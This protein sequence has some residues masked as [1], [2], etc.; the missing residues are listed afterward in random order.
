[1]QSESELKELALKAIKYLKD[2][3]KEKEVQSILELSYSNMPKQTPYWSV[4]YLLEAHLHFRNQNFAGFREAWTS[5]KEDDIDKV[6]L[7]EVKEMFKNYCEIWQVHL[8]TINHSANLENQIIE[9]DFTNFD[10]VFELAELLENVNSKKAVEILFKILDKEASWK[11]Y[12]AAKKCSL[13]LEKMKDANFRA[14]HQRRLIE[15]VKKK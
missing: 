11:N 4:F 10:R 13:I 7:P 2:P 6:G 3:K 5:L 15:I 8:K 9:E 1:M 12:I 14:I